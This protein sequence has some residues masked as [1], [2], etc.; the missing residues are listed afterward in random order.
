MLRELDASHLIET[1]R[2]LARRVEE[3]FPD[4]GL[5]KVAKE[6]EAV[7]QEG[8][9]FARW[10][11]RPLYPLRLLVGAFVFVLMGAVVWGFAHVPLEVRATQL[12]DVAQLVESAINDIVFLGIAVF[13]AVGLEARIKRR[14][15]LGALHVLRS[16]A[17]IVDMHQLTKDPERLLYPDHN[18]LSSPKR[19]MT[20][21][22]LT[23]YLDYCGEILALTGKL[24]ALYVQHF[25]DSDTV[26]A[27]ASIDALTVGLSQKI[28]Q[29][30][31][32]LDR[33]TEGAQ[34]R[35]RPLAP[36]DV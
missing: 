14:R 31:V 30:I 26:A 19:T 21:F 12:T 36:R 29:K 20:A 24:G 22:E 23:R 35:H 15:A 13:F 25:D 16:V 2:V 17:H 10:L 6:L 33:V 9:Q 18:T 1:A 11:A 34:A 7:T 3:R 27:A 28:W 4:S 5:A 8:A 32:I